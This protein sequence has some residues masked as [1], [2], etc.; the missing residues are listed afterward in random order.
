MTLR[1]GSTAAHGKQLCITKVSM[2]VRSFGFAV[3]ERKLHEI[4]R[5]TTTS[6]LMNGYGP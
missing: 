4:R 5:T 3:F 1:G 2:R 6:D